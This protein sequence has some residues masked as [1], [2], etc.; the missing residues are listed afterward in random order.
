MDAF[1]RIVGEGWGKREM[2]FVRMTEK[3]RTE[4]QRWRTEIQR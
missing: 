3:K 2:C 4:I 1:S